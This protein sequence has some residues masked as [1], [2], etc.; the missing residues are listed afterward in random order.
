MTK[1]TSAAIWKIIITLTLAGSIHCG[2]VLV[3][4]HDGSHWVNMNI[5]I[6]ELHNRGHNV[7]VIRAAD[8]WYIKEQSPY[9]HSITIDFSVG[10]DKAFFRTFVSRQLE[11]RRE[12]KPFWT[13]ISLDMEMSAMFSE[14]HR[15]MCEMVIC[16]IED[17]K[18]IK[19]IR[20]TDYD[21]MLTDPANGGGVVLAHF[22]N[23]PLVFN[24]RWTVHGEAHFA[25]APSPASF[26]PFPLSML[27]DKMTFFQRVYNVLFHLRLYFYKG[28]V[29]PHYRA[30][31]KRYFG[32]DVDYFE[33]F[34][35]ADI[36]L[37]RVDFVFE[38]PRPTMPNVVYMSC[39][40]CK[41][42]K[43]LPDDLQDFAESSG[44]HGIVVVS[45]G[46]LIGKLPDDITNEMA[47]ALAKL[48][49]KVI[50]RYTGKKPSTLGNNTLLRDWLPQN[51]L[52]GHPKTKLFVSHGGT[53]GILEAIYHGTPIV[54]LPLV[55][56]QQDNLSRMK[57]KGVA[58]V[59][60]IATLNQN[61]FLE[62]IQEVINEPT[63]GINM[64]RLSRLSRD[65]PIEP[66]DN[67]MFWI[68]FV[69]RHRGAAHLRTESYK[70]PWYAYHSVDVVVFLL[71][72]ASGTVFLIFA[73][74]QYVCCR[75][76]RKKRVK[77]D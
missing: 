52:L 66:L 3:F 63:Y 74:V 58:Q 60:D 14:M 76:C 73:L 38:F 22:L 49:Q 47:A 72:V 77:Q 6:Q 32:P 24:V 69:M 29:G 46:T 20:E 5:L 2:K 26:V 4:P 67:A 51:D 28:I 37:M 64:K 11:V 53:N 39:F 25:I 57:G 17:Q 13:R 68:E 48:P 12:G 1:K 42:A 8:S 41:P 56:D 34:Q 71:S 44:E 62:A 18:L 55:F 16:I 9:Y 23:L 33:L 45:L 31:C 70:M 65:T 75:S 10:V 15:K 40:Q 30:L 50:W 59:I 61:M 36:W 27:T 19:S 35:A 21:V 7:T 54:G 43:A